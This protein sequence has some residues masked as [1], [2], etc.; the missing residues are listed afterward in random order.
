MKGINY[1]LSLIIALTTL[2]CSCT[3]FL[4]EKPDKMLAIPTSLQ[5][6]EAV[7]NGPDMMLEPAEGEVMTTD[8]FLIDDDFEAMWCPLNIDLYLWQDN[9]FI[10]QCDG[11]IGWELN[12]Q[13]IYRSNVVLEG[14]HKYEAN[15]GISEQS[16]NIKGHA[17]FI[18]GINH[19]GIAQLWA[20]AYDKKTANT[21]LGIPLRLSSDFN[22]PTIRP[23]LQVTMERIEDDL[24]KAADLLPD[25]QFSVRLPSKISAWA[26]LAR[27]YL[28][29]SD[30]EKAKY[31]SELCID[32]GLELISFH[33]YTYT[34]SFPFNMNTNQ[35]ILYARVLNT[36]YES[37]NINLRRVDKELYDSYTE[38]DLRKS[39]YFTTNPDGTIRFRGSYSGG[40]GGLFS[41]P[42]LNEMY[43]VAAECHAR[44]N[45]FEKA[46][47][48]LF[49]LLQHRME[50]D[51]VFT[52]I[53]DG[54]VL[55]EVLK[56]RRK[57]LLMRGI[58][59]CD[60]KRLNALGANVSLKRT[61]RGNEYFLSP[62]SPNYTLL[63]PQN[64]VEIS[65]VTQNGR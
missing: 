47:E 58:R 14:L 57:E 41:G 18:R 54:N 35:E 52:D 50:N 28:Y 16:N 45:S 39:I 3:S 7:L 5:D 42:A 24:L 21:V 13:A 31:Y 10:E 64:V 38:G 8:Y 27:F 43:L 2:M 46:K 48:Y 44:L 62:N 55:H 11:S 51:Y 4:G 61:A 60:L 53:V 19:L 20:E 37:L 15:N 32:S 65:G 23:S 9:S 59:F 29:I 22:E 17:F 36:A 25:R 6:F 1:Y 56:E 33:S 40:G 34:G 26:Y 63:I 12:Y 49:S 30:F